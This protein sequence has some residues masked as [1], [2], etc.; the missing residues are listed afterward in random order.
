MALPST[1]PGSSAN[2][3]EIADDNPITFASGEPYTLALL[4]L[5]KENPSTEGIFRSGS[6]S[7][8]NWLLILSS[9]KLRGRQGNAD[10]P[11]SGSGPAIATGW[12]TLARVWDGQQVRGSTWTA[13]T[14]TRSRS[15]RPAYAWPTSAGGLFVAS[16]MGTLRQ[17]SAPCR[18]VLHLHLLALSCLSAERCLSYL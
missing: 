2:E 9:G 8:G 16:V 1:L 17:A 4:I 15:P 3:V 5:W 11:G 18:H 12:R 13:C 7:N 14:P 10:S 6:S